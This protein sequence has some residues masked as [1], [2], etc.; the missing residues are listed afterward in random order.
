MKISPY[1]YSIFFDFIESYL[2]SGFQDIHADDP[3]MQELEKIME[4][5]DQ[6]LSV[7]NVD[8][9][10]YLYTSRRSMQM[11]GIESTHFNPAH[12]LSAVHPDDLDK[13]SW[14][15][16]QLLKVGG[17]IFE[18]KK[19]TALLS[20]TLRLRNPSGNYAK[21]L[22]QNYFFYTAVPKKGVLCI[23]VYTN[24]DWCKLKNNCF[25]QYVGNDLSLFKFPDEQLLKIAQIYSKR[26][27]EIIKLIESGLS[28]KEVA[29]K[30]F[31][32]V[33]TVNTHRS[34][35]LAK[36]GK[37]HLSDLIYELKEQGLI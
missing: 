2:P 3:I 32:S 26:E 33:F 23:R 28:S 31:L 36:S 22:G 7:I 18:D 12:L 29:A 34:N 15:N 16:G 17:E 10:R 21:V 14:V 37:S 20:F 19:E 4:E 9:I 8:Q 27:L 24:I 30:L 6:F 35:I 5:H 1:N 11:L 25:H 13:L